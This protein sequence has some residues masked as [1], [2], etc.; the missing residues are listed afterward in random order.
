MCGPT[1]GEIVYF[2][3]GSGECLFELYPFTDPYSFYFFVHAPER[4]HVTGARFRFETDAF[5][6]GDVTSL[7]RN[8]DV[9]IED[10][11]PFGGIRISWTSLDL[12]HTAVL[13]MTVPYDS[14]DQFAGFD[15]FRI[16][17][18]Y[19]FFESGDSLA[20][21]GAITGIGHVNCPS[22]SITWDTPDT[23]KIERG[24]WLPITVTWAVSAA[25]I[26]GTD[27][28]VT[29]EKGWVTSYSPMSIW[30]DHC[31]TCPWDGRD[32]VIYVLIPS[33]VPPHTM[34]ELTIRPLTCCSDKIITIE[35]IPHVATEKTS[36]GKI[37]KSRR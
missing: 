27:I 36:W 6:P 9:A 12:D 17:D 28:E 19:I 22:P 35:A 21:D 18:A 29:D 37:K 7:V 2:S 20:V 31:P 23:V 34:D 11:D 10:G 16:L 3:Q 26:W 8:P 32:L 1:W 30:G 15:C 25:Y 5:E 14:I 13:A 4:S 24:S 33:S